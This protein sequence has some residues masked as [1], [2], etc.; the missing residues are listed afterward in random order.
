[1]QVLSEPVFQ[2]RI[3]VYTGRDI[4]AA[5]RKVKTFDADYQPRP[6]NPSR[7]GCCVSLQYLPISVLW[8]HPDKVSIGIVVHE[9]TH[10]VSNM[11]DV[12]GCDEET[13]CYLTEYYVDGIWALCSPSGLSGK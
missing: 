11:V 7:S 12:L 10:A 8:L 2:S 1:M 13:R 9:V 5:Y 6:D 3:Y 4:S